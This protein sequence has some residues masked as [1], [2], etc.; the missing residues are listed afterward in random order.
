MVVDQVAVKALLERARRE[1]E[2][3][4]LPS[5]QIAL[6]INS[7]I[8]AFE[9]FG[10]GT[11]DTRYMVWSATKPFVAGAIWALMG[12]DAIDVARPVIHYIP[13]FG[14]NGKEAITVEQVMLH[15]S[16]VPSAPMSPI[17]GDTSAGR[18]AAFAR[19]RLNWEPGSTCE[20]HPSSAHWVLA[21]II[22][23]VSGMDFRTVVEQRVSRPAG[24]PRVLGDVPQIGAELVSVG[25][26]ATPDE[27]EAALGVREL[28]LGEVTHA[29]LLSFND[30]AIQRVGIPGGGGVMT[31]A[32]LALYHQA[33]LHN[34]GEMWRP[35]IL[36]DATTNVRNNLG[37]R[38]TGIASRRTLGLVQAGDDGL[39]FMRGMGR[40]VS[41]ATTGHNGAGGQ[42]AWADPVSGLSLGYCTNGLDQHYIREQRRTTAIASLAGVCAS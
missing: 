39:A 41:A 36:A 27:L 17:E 21:E 1:V 16:G 30:P 25:E 28:D 40:T 5:V 20:Y 29:A 34:P 33:I 42:I 7:E 4:L 35:D 23:R 3:G 26:P 6:A 11:N 19:W 32:D 38:L 2:S 14:T 15:T 13:E 24:L 10:D 9:T 12:D 18:V 31:A 8:I 37:N 22:D